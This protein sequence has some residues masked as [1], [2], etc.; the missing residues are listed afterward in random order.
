MYNSQIILGNLDCLVVPLTEGLT[1]RLFS[2]SKHITKIIG[3]CFSFTVHFIF[4]LA[5]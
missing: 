3:E 5:K 2:P 4:S 1:P